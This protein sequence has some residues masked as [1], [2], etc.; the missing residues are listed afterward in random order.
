NGV[1]IPGATG[2]SLVLTNIQFTNAGTYGVSVSN[3][4]GAVTSSNAM[5]TVFDPPPPV[6][7]TQPASQV[8]VLGGGAIFS[9]VIAS[10]EPPTFQWR[11]DGTALIGATNASLLLSN[12]QANQA[13]GYSVVARTSSGSVTSSVAT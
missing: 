1:D 3:Q 6:I 11:M 5:L 8:T 9:V 10:L 12:V 13:G 7:V 2:V 4:I